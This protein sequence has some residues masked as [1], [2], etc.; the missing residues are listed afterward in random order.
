VS[1]QLKKN[2]P[3]DTTTAGPDAPDVV[4]LIALHDLFAG[5][6]AGIP[7]RSEL[8]AED[9]ERMSAIEA[10]LETARSASSA[11]GSAWKGPAPPET[12]AA[13]K[14][15]RAVLTVTRDA[16]TRTVAGIEV[17]T[18]AIEINQ[19]RK[20]L[21]TRGAAT[22]V[23]I[24]GAIEVARQRDMDA[25]RE[26]EA[27]LDAVDYYMSDFAVGGVLR[28]ILTV[29]SEPTSRGYVA[30]TLRRALDQMIE[31]RR[32]DGCDDEGHVLPVFTIEDMLRDWYGERASDEIRASVP[33]VAAA[34][35]A[36]P[37]GPTVP[38]DE[39]L[40]RSV[41][42]MMERRRE[43]EEAAEEAAAHEPGVRTATQA[44]EQREARRAAR[45]AQRAEAAD[46]DEEADDDAND[47]DGAE[48][49]IRPRRQRLIKVPGGLHPYG[50]PAA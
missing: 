27:Q 22:L 50:D 35:D 47:G 14:G 40:V 3:P 15:V 32:Q 45:E 43:R 10:A 48:P 2:T 4:A 9:E 42:E 1:K 36:T 5:F 21:H 8:A 38:H 7:A 44:T 19:V 18:P 29:L 11:Y 41:G 17:S 16:E 13:L 6:V 34:Y 33:S 37:P 30:D 23:A 12:A 39:P 31:I 20:T 28:A 24:V 26:R 46:R 49:D 25:A